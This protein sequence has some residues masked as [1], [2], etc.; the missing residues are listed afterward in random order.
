MFWGTPPQTYFLDRELPVGSFSGSFCGTPWG[1]LPGDP[2]NNRKQPKIIF[3]FNKNFVPNAS[4]VVAVPTALIV[5]NEQLYF[6]ETTGE[7]FFGLAR[8]QGD[9]AADTSKFNSTGTFWVSGTLVGFKTTKG[10]LQ[11]FIVSAN[12][13]LNSASIGDAFTIFFDIFE[14]ILEAFINAFSLKKPTVS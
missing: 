2:K 5:K 6:D 1:L 7:G 10:W 4:P 8:E 11:E 12:N 3:A 9:S 14:K 13:L